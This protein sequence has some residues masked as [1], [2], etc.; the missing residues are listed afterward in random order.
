[1]RSLVL[2]A[3][4]VYQLA[5]SPYLPGAC[6]YL[7][8]CSSYTHEAVSRYGAPRGLWLGIR[9]FCRCQPLGTLGYDPVP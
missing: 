4:D 1:M 5:V 6:R 3:I 9:R 2:K 8:S 7:P